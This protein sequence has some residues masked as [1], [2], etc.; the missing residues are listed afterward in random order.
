MIQ[1]YVHALY[2]TASSFSI[3][4]NIF[5]AIYIVTFIP[6][7][8]VIALL[9][10]AALARRFKLVIICFV[11]EIIL[12]LLPYLYLL[13][14]A[15]GVPLLYYVVFIILMLLVIYLTYRKTFKRIKFKE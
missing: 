2:E 1:D 7:W 4:P 9:V 10:K 13:C 6:C 11:I 8:A 14:F 15:R 3:N 12:L 5:I